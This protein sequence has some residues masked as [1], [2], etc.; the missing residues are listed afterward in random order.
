MLTLYTTPLS[1]NGRKPLALCLHLGLR[2]EVR[3]VNV[4]RGEGQA[5]AFLAVSPLGKV[6]ALV[7]GDLTLT[8]SNA[9]LQYLAEAYGEGRVGGQDAKG[10]AEV[11]RWMFWEASHWQPSMIAVPGLAAAVAAKL[12]IPGVVASAEGVRWEEHAEWTRMARH[13]DGHLAGREWLVG[14][15]EGPTIADFAVAGMMTYSRSAGFPFARYAGIARWY[16]RV[17][18]LEAWKA[19]AAEVWR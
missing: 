13:L 14:K 16:E 12:G 8:E 17:E 3:D 10:R 1:A 6:P 9:I 11:A 4:Y 5:P 2:L 19:S 15:G 7:D 18:A